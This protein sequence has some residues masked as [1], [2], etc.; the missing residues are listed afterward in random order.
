MIVVRLSLA[1]S[2]LTPY[3]DFN[4]YAANK[5]LVTG[6]GSGS[7]FLV[8][9]NIP[10]KHN[11]LYNLELYNIPTKQNLLYELVLYNIPTE[12]NLLYKL[13]LYNIPT[14]H[15]ASTSKHSNKVQYLCIAA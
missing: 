13:V 3:Q 15:N 10:T 6:A 12:H 7:A 4:N 5:L 14:K 2:H 9:Y 11:L 8:L 1:T